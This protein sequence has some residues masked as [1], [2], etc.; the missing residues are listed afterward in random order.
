VP[1]EQI[2]QYFDQADVMI[3]SSFMEGVPVVLMEAMAKELGVVSTRVG[4]VPELIEDGVTGFLVDPGSSE[5]LAAAL[6]KYAAQPS[7]CRVHGERGRQRVI[8]DYGISSTAAGMAQ[9]FDR[10]GIEPNATTRSNRGGEP[11]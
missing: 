5:S 1:Q 9:L 10:Y 8:K 3:V 4:G 2:Q 11:R 6:T 7:L